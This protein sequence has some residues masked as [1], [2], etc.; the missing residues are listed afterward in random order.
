MINT[1]EKGRAQWEHVIA[2]LC[3]MKTQRVR[4]NFIAYFAL[5]RGMA[6]GGGNLQH[7][8]IIMMEMKGKQ[9]KPDHFMYQHVVS[10]SSKTTEIDRVCDL[11]QVTPSCALRESLRK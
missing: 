7:M 11:L 2:V 8:L 10:T 9:M 1:C 5:I 6:L 3:S 4:L